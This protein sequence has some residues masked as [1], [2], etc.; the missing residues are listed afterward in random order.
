MTECTLIRGQKNPELNDFVYGHR[1]CV[2]ACVLAGHLILGTAW[3]GSCL[4]WWSGADASGVAA[5]GAV[6]LK[7]SLE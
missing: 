4:P 6:G 7:L 2:S 3:F 5:F 1:A